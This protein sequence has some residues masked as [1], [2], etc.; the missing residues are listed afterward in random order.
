MTECDEIL[1]K[2]FLRAVLDADTAAHLSACPRCAAEQ[3]HV[4]RVAEL[5][6]SHD[7]PPPDSTLSAR[8]LGAA[9]PLLAGHARRAAWR[10]FVRA[11][12]AALVPLP[13]ILFL[14]VYV[15]RTAYGVLDALL[16]HALSLYVVFNYAAT[17]T[18][19]LA[20]TYGMIPIVAERQMRL[21]REESRA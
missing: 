16:P 19:L 17:L 13:L 18:L 2:L 4:R 7:V 1:A 9:A 12:A 20:L 14:D 6:A 21:R 10:T 11:L 5:L 8:V 15:M 3:V